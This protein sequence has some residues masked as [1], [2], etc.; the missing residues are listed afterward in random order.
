MLF[1]E[2]LV[3]FERCSGIGDIIC[4]LPSL[5]AI[6]G[7]H[8]RARIVFA[9]KKEFMPIAVMSGLTKVVAETD[10]PGDVPKVGRSDYDYVYDAWL[11]EERPNGVSRLHL[12]DDFAHNLKVRLTDRQPHLS[13][14]EAVI[15]RLTARSILPSATRPLVGMH[16]GPSWPVREWT[17]EGWTVLAEM[18]KRD[19]GATIVQLGADQHVT[20]G[21][22]KTPRIEGVV[23]LVGKLSLE[24]TVAAISMCNLF[25]G[26]DSGLLHVSGA[27]GVPSVGL[28]G[29]VN[30]A[31]RLP[32]GTPSEAVVAN[33]PCIGCHHRS[34]RLHWQEGCPH[35]IACMN[36]I[37][38]QAVLDAC[39][40]MLRCSTGSGTLANYDGNADD[41]S[42]TRPVSSFKAC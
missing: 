2:P 26:I 8:P 6:R 28:F 18:L 40:R 35:E 3:L 25:V 30:P 42:V 17:V 19:C 4:S 38:P 10:W 36:S 33:L 16:V 39:R 37:E 15:K 20:R 5:S 9:T 21:K 34:P 41:P 31:L 32:R 22:V 13:I 1:K 29:P 12:T 11:E 27:V 14:G 24:E 23:D 7:L